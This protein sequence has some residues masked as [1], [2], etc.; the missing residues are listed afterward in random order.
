MYSSSL[1]STSSGHKD[2]HSLIKLIE[3][4]RASGIYEQLESNLIPSW[5]DF[6]K[7]F[8]LSISIQ[9][10]YSELFRYYYGSLTLK[11]RDLLIAYSF[12]YYDMD[13]DEALCF[14][15]KELIDC[16]HKEPLDTSYR[17]KLY[18]C[19]HKFERIYIPW[20]LDDRSKILEKLSHMYWEYE[21]NY[22]L[23][24]ARLTSQE[25]E[26]FLNEKTTKQE[27][28]IDVMKKMDNLHFFNQYQPVYVDS[29]TSSL[30]IEI[31]R[32]AFWDRIK[33][34]L[35]KSE[36]DYEPLFSIF[37]EIREH[38]VAIHQRRPNI[39]AQ[40]DE[41]IDIEYFKQRQRYE[42][43]DV[44]F[45]MSRLT[46]LIDILIEMDSPNKES[47]HKDYLQKISKD[48]EQANNKKLQFEHCIDGL[49]YIMTRLLEIR[50]LY[51][52]VF[53]SSI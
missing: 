43:L 2:V 44:S 29:G 12:I 23:Y 52:H 40:Y 9:K 32:K 39:L 20:K 19:I 31:L 42:I 21:V 3:R 47:K 1:P 11:T 16:I 49:A 36:P 8:L 6:Q 37:V 33:D 41:I 24:E 46:F 10:L 5:E 51:D 35:F 7:R 15:A 18:Q 53:A 22:K 4:I 30:L 34:S 28:C 25:K 26:Y 13:K 27:E 50:E 45:W 38:L 48:I 17:S 14:A